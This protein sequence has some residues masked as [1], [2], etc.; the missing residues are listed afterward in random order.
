MSLWEHGLSIADVAGT[1]LLRPSDL[2]LIARGLALRGEA[3]FLIG[4]DRLIP[5]AD[6]D[7][8]TRDARPV[9]YRLSISESG[10][11]RSMIALA[12]EVLHFRIGADVVAPYHGQAPLRRAAISSGLLHAIE[13]ALRETFENAPIGSLIVP[14]PESPQTDTEQLSRGFRGRRGSVLLRE[15]VNVTAAGGPTPQ[16]DWRPND[17][18]PDLRRSMTAESL[19]A[20]RE[21]ICSVFGVLPALF[22]NNAQ[23]PLVREAERHLAQWMLQPICELIAEEAS[24]KLGGDVDLDCISPLQAFDHGGRARAFAGMIDALAVAKAAGLSPA[25]TA[26][27]LKF[28]DEGSPAER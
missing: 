3:L 27:A 11:G 14:F 19:A 9:A 6:W 20:A 15:S 8:R 18:S 10:G 7:L 17:L 4:D 2:A 24:A 23:G 1:N 12:A 28:I 5:A 22:A 21:A 13:S 25:E 26:F 16:T